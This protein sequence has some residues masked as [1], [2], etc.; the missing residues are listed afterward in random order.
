[1]T[2]IELNHYQVRMLLDVVENSDSPDKTTIVIQKGQGHS[3]DGLYAY[4]K[5]HPDDGS[6][7]IGVDEDDQR[8]GD[9]E[10]D[11][12]SAQSA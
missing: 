3:G 10:G 7:F 11:A 4:W 9:A 5:S 1:M 6:E 8:R 2:S 12:Y